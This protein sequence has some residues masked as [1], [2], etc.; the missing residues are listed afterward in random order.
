MCR[1]PVQRN[2]GGE[3]PVDCP[4]LISTHCTAVSDH[5]IVPHDC[6]E[7]LCLLP[8]IRIKN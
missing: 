8:S 7:L 1:F 3:G 2:V 6:V 4:D 5:Y